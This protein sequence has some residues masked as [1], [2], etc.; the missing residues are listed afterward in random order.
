MEF[1]IYLIALIC[2]CIGNVIG[3]AEGAIKFADKH[4]KW[5]EEHKRG[6]EDSDV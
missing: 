3:F 5:I 6:E 4:R 1:K 2:F